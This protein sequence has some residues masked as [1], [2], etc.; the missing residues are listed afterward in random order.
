MYYQK[1]VNETLKLCH[2][3]IYGLSS[4]DVKLHQEKYGKN[5]LL[6]QKK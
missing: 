4:Q 3:S 2:S 1:T 5:V 6:K